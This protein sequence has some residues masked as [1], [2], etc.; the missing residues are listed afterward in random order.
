MK[1]GHQ[2]MSCSVSALNASRTLANSSLGI[3]VEQQQAEPTCKNEMP[4]HILSF[5]IR[6]ELKYDIKN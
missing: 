3:F 2:K 5:T 1:L 4:V 6:R